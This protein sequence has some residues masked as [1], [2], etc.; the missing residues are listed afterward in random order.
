MITEG[1]G[2]FYGSVTVSKRGQIV[3]PSQA[4]RDLSI[5]VGEKL[6]VVSGPSGGI[7]LV[8]ADVVAQVL[9]QWAGLIRRIEEEGL[10][11]ASEGVDVI[12]VV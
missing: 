10:S 7:I 12:E 6:L 8:R 2:Q 11:E 3:I 1:G 5:E 4:R 9:G